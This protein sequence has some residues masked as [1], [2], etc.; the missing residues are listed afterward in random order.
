MT[1]SKQQ[2][3]DTVEHISFEMNRYLYTAHPIVSLPGRYGEA[4][5]E[6][7]LLHSRAI[8]E[9]FFEEEKNKDDVRI[10]HYYDE[11]ISKKELQ[12]E[13]EKSKSKWA[14][15]KKRI[16]KKMG[17]LTFTRVNTVPMHMQE[18]N[19][20]NFDVLIELFERNLPMEFR[21]KWELGKSFSI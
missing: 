21:E 10:S 15:Y 8:G 4:V 2:L 14:D 3:I 7:C 12:D 13:I 1:P 17:H 16:N 5:A 18:K 19:E 11:L 20:L 9:F 6:S